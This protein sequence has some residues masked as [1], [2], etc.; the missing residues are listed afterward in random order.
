MLLT[1]PSKGR[2]GVLGPSTS[3]AGRGSGAS[4]G[5]YLGQSEGEGRREQSEGEAVRYHRGWIRVS[6]AL[7]ALVRLAVL[8]NEAWPQNCEPQAARN[9]DFLLKSG[10]FA[11]TETALT[12]LVTVC[13]TNSGCLI[14]FI[15]AIGSINVFTDLL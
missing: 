11:T 8:S 12:P 1:N 10:I 9:C 7:G 15:M 6:W 13:S 5:S 2:S 14:G 4:R 3:T